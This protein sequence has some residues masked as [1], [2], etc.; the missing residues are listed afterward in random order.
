MELRPK[1][2]R[3]SILRDKRAVTHHY[4]L[5][6]E[7]F[8]LFLDESMTY[9]CAIWSRGATTLEE[10][11]RTKLELVCTK[12][13]LQPGDRVLDVGCGWG[14]FAIHAAREHG[15]ARHRDHAERAAGVAGARARGGGGR[16]RPGRHPRHG[17]PRDRGRDVRRD[18]LDRDGRARR[19]RQHRHLRG[20]ARLAAEARRAAA[21]PRDRA[22]ARRR[23]RGGRVLRALRVPG[24]RAA[25]PLADPAR[26]R[27]RRACTPATS[28]TSRTTTRGRCWSGS[29][30]SRPTS[31]GRASWAATSACACGGSTCASRARASRA[32]SCP[33]TRCAPS[34]RLS[35]LAQQAAVHVHQEVDHLGIGHRPARG[36]T[37]QDLGA[38]ADVGLAERAGE[39]AGDRGVDDVA[40]PASAPRAP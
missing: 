31:S 24:R 25:A 19:Q 20:Q 17:L 2:R 7:Y 6:N 32:A 11:Q 38:R 18:R 1:G 12:L 28:R 34:N 40:R 33:S 13:G 39:R 15:V 29:G 9:S 37:A 16:R 30:A 26:A 21:Q 23:R 5:S 10:A 35:P 22:A 8:A 36:L 3:H 14:A 27:A 4:N